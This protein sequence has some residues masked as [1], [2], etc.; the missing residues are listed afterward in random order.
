MAGAG[1]LPPEVHVSCGSMK[2]HRRATPA[3]GLR[4]KGVSI[5]FIRIYIYIIDIY[6]ASRASPAVG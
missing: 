3:G 6:C 4:Q 5:L 1:A 2:L